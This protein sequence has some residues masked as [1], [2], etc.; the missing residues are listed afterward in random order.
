MAKVIKIRRGLDIRLKGQAEKVLMKAERS[1]SYAVK[2]V[3]FFNIRP[4]L[5]VKVGDQVKAGT[6]L[7]FNKYVPEV[8]FCSPVSGTVTAINRGERRAIQEV[9]IEPDAELQ[10]ESFLKAD[11]LTLS[12]EQITENLL[13]SGLWPM[14]KQRP[15]GIIARPSEKPRSIF[16]SAF[17]SSPLAPDYDFILQDSF[18]DFQTGINA[19]TRLT[20]GSVHLN[21]NADYPPSDV[22][23]KTQNV[24]INRFSGPHPSGNVG[25]QIH[26]ID[27]IHKNGVV[28]TVNP[29]DVVIIGR[30]FSK[31]IFD[32]TKIIALAGSEVLRPRYYKTMMG[33]SIVPFVEKN[34]NGGKLRYISG[35]VLTGRKIPHDGYLGFFDSL[36]T[37]IPEGDYF[38]LFGWAMPGF[39]KFSSSRSFFSWLNPGK[40]YMV[41]TN[42]H[43]GERAYVIT[44]QYES[45]LPM[46]ILPVHLIKSILIEDIDRMENLGIYEV[47]E[48]DLALCEFVCTSKTEV[49]SI[50]R[51]GIEQMIRETS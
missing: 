32:A 36:I 42:Y 41:D 28:W 9:V 1:G 16:V 31:G 21:V 8:R 29:Q 50:L 15:F 23:T 30:L 22:S 44:G 43:G 47:I 17:D 38:E 45:V 40:E 27:P 14:L 48:E 5:T 35:N 2:P 34:V 25:V 7:F 6:V 51:N 46:D 3:D 49:Q 4:K 13:K 11:P 39:N 20:D 18:D 33:A 10:Y 26:H 12:R 37:V 24:Q 19:L